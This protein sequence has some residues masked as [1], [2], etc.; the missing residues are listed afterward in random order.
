MITF[1]YFTINEVY[2]FF[3]GIKN[4]NLREENEEDFFFWF[5]TEKNSVNDKITD[6]RECIIGYQ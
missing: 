1:S 2:I 6:W 3:M 5:L 4:Y